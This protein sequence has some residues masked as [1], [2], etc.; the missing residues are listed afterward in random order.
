MSR[1]MSDLVLALFVTVALLAL[2]LGFLAV[3]TYRQVSVMIVLMSAPRKVRSLLRK[4]PWWSILSARLPRVSVFSKG[5]KSN[6][7]YLLGSVEHTGWAG[8]KLMRQDSV[9]LLATWPS[10][11]DST[12]AV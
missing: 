7:G 5:P 1:L 8:G 12:T 9:S 11:R 3:T 4:H 10:G 6:L 2:L